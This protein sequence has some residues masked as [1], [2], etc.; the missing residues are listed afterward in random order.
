MHLIPQHK[1]SARGRKGRGHGPTLAVQEAFPISNS[2]RGQSQRASFTTVRADLAISLSRSARP[3]SA[4][5]AFVIA[6]YFCFV[7][8]SVSKVEDK[9]Q[10]LA[11][12]I[13][14]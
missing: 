6:R 3:K 13:L 11:T 1:T 9:Y 5:H 8:H 10:S 12:H 4:C 14:S 2:S 7:A